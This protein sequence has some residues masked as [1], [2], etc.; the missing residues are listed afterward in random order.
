MNAKGNQSPETVVR[1]A[2]DPLT[3]DGANLSLLIDALSIAPTHFLKNCDGT[4]NW[5]P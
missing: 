5:I 4:D 2:V 1:D 3:I